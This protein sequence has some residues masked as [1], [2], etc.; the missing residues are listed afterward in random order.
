MR[1]LVDELLQAKVKARLFGGDHA[2]RLG[3]LVILDRLGSGAMGT[4]FTAY[5]PRLDRKV[6]VKLLRPGSGGDAERVIREARA[7]GK[8]AHPN[9]VA[10]HDVGELDG[11]VF[12]VME[13]AP[14]VP[15]RTWIAG[16]RDWKDVVRVMAEAAAGLA[17][18]HRAGLVHRDI[19]PDNILIGD[20]RTRI[21]DFGL[22]HDRAGSDDGN[23][24]GTPS[25][26]AP[27]VL[28]E[29][30]ASEASDQFSFGVTLYEA[31][32]GVRP[33]TG[34]TRDE[35]RVSAKT[36]AS[37][38][39]AKSGSKES[40]Q[41]TVDVSAETESAPAA[42][43]GARDR[44]AR[45]EAEAAPAREP[46]DSNT[47]PARAAGVSSETEG[48]LPAFDRANPSAR[49]ERGAAETA[50]ASRGTGDRS[51]ASRDR[52]GDAGVRTP[53][54][55]SS[56]KVIVRSGDQRARAV[57]SS[58]PSWLH[59]LVVRALAA[60]ASKRF[61]SMDALAAALGRDRR[62]KRTAAGIVAIA[63]IAGATL[64]AI[65]Y[66]HAKTPADP[67]DGGAP[68][69]EA[70]WGPSESGRVKAS[71]ATAPWATKVVE[72]LDAAA[73]QWEASF[74]TVCE[75]SRVKGA[76]SD[77]LLDLRM[78]CLDRS[79]DRFGALTSALAAPLDPAARAEATGAVADLPDPRACETIA[80]AGELA[81]PT[82]PTK[83]A[84]ITAA[85]RTLDR[86]W[87]AYSLGRYRDARDV[88]ASLG[89]T[90]PLG[91]AALD[92]ATLLLAAAVEARIGEPS[93][94]RALLE[95]ALAAAAKA[96][97]TE[98]EAEVWARLLRHELFAGTPANAI[99]WAPF[100]LAAA[101]RAGREGAEID[102][103]IGEALRD[104]GRL[105]QARER[106]AKALAST[107][108]LRGDRRALIEMNAGSVELAA[109]S[110]AAAE[111]LFQQALG[112]ARSQLGDGHPTLAIYLDKL[113]AADR[114]RGRIT[115]ALALHDQSVA[116][117]TAAYGP[118]DRSTA[119]SLLNRARTLLEA[120]RLDDAGKDAAAALD[121]RSTHLG[122]TSPR[123]GEILVVQGDI[124]L[125][126]GNRTAAL[127]L[128][129]RAASLDTRI[130][131]LARRA[132]AGA[133]ISI[134]SLPSTLDP[135]TAER[136]AALAVRVSKLRPDEA[137]PIVNAL[138]ARLG[139]IKPPVDPAIALPI[140]EA[141]FLAAQSPA[142]QAVAR[143]VLEQLAPEPSRARA[144]AQR[145]LEATLK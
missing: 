137:Q 50:P 48:V 106:L 116:V 87:A 92:A 96:H 126:A 39:P 95:S 54:D 75:A 131:I 133:D 14:G 64:G 132:A 129:D 110:P 3:R 108:K 2:P 142:A 115:D 68:R 67:C 13:L 56:G 134:A 139:A 77:T 73:G 15:L 97:A 35:L 8:L 121:I 70:V 135:L 29:H 85:E 47:G 12:I 41:D 59:A 90:E 55:R 16:D 88:L 69:R 34:R 98:L 5:D 104:A 114:A 17:A 80:D 103:I 33:H 81:L 46:A 4:V 144:R 127:A 128:Y 37:A 86:A 23:S 71:L 83:R 52:S 119:S 36:A 63:G 113:A 94:A 45:T 31:L 99:E 143:S 51:N 9:V 122:A 78:R 109:G 123:L 140:G 138:R 145:L 125:E 11:E 38:R 20:D 102:G 10:V 26:M 120:N 1:D 7:L 19:K 53:S 107:D 117:R 93:K 62:R 105:D 42:A 136:A 72:S 49:T 100:A 28:D 21:V 65:A 141:L 32:Y 91:S 57:R 101:A 24:A 82:D 130:D 74:R 40:V 30:A 112:H 76:Q 25:Y 124:M 27:E 58:P 89:P 22:A 61:P 18:A 6:A 111:A 66:R 60:D 84:Q 44:N 43:D 79:L 118:T